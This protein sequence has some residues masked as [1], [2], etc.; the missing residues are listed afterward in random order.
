MANPRS[1]LSRRALLIGAAP[2]VTGAIASIG[3]FGQALVAQDARSTREGSSEGRKIWSAEYWAEKGDVKLYLYRKRIGPPRRGQASRPVL[4]LV[5]GSTF[6]GRESFDLSFPG[7]ND[8]SAMDKYA[9]DGFDVWTMDFEGYGRSS[10]TPGNS[11]IA[12]GD[13]DLKA[14]ECVV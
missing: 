8:Y 10:R 3:P 11:A 12:S 14:P 9:E 5:H 4:F 2:V 13:A 7:H 1:H 6:P